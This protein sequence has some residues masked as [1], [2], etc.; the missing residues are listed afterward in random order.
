LSHSRPV[1]RAH[2]R[3]RAFEPGQKPQDYVLGDGNRAETGAVGQHQAALLEQVERPAVDAGRQGGHPL[4][5]AAGID[6]VIDRP[7]SEI[8]PENLGPGHPLHAAVRVHVP[9]GFDGRGKTGEVGAHA[10]G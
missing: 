2:E 1:L 10:L 8:K 5:I 7:N 6:D 9:G 3:R 4:E